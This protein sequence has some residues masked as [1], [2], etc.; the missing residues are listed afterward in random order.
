MSSPPS[1][2]AAVGQH[3]LMHAYRGLSAQRT[4][5]AVLWSCPCEELSSQ[6][7]DNLDHK[8]GDSTVGNASAR[9]VGVGGQ[10]ELHGQRARPVLRHPAGG[11]GVPQKTGCPCV[12]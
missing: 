5:H 8:A 4:P 10:S 11:K 9:G 6:Q 12:D 2:A 1:R 7:A 3:G